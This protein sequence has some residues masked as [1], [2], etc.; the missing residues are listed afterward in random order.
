MEQT[1]PQF[2]SLDSNIVFCFLNKKRFD[3]EFSCCPV[4]TL[5]TDTIFCGMLYLGQIYFPYSEINVILQYQGHLTDLRFCFLWIWEELAPEDVIR[6][7][8]K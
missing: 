2:C 6:F 8:R 4:L 5:K 1:H 3:S 7:L